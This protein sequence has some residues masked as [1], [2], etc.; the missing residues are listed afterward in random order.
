MRRT[1][2]ALLGFCWLLHGQEARAQS[3]GQD[4][5]WS[6]PQV[7]FSP[8]REREGSDKPAYT[9]PYRLEHRWYGWQTLLVDAASVGLAVVT[10]NAY[11]F[12]GGYWIFPPVL[13]LGHGQPSRAIGSLGLRVALPFIGMG[14]GSGQD[15]NGEDGDAGLV[16]GAL[17]GLVVASILDAAWL[18]WKDERV[19]VNQALSS[20]PLFAMTQHSAIGGWQGSF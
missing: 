18:S 10:Q 3:A 2:P 15:G 13:H 14:L 6:P 12:L 5:G 1:L 20:A 11:V 8:A 17:T 19:P 9:G 16:Y 7:S 4:L